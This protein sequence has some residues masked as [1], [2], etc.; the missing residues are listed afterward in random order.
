MAT[1]FQNRLIGTVILVS[2]G[3][4]FLPDLLMGKK[5]DISA[6]PGSLPLRPEQTMVTSTPAESNAN[7]TAVVSAGQ[8]AQVVASQTPVS[9][10]NAVTNSSE[11]V[12][13]SGS[14]TSWQVEDV[15]P[16]VTI[17]ENNT[18]SK[19]VTVS[20]KAKVQPVASKTTTQSVNEKLSAKQTDI[21]TKKQETVK[22]VAAEKTESVNDVSTATVQA[23][24]QVQKDDSGLTIKTPAQVEAE[25][26]A[27]SSAATASTTKPA[28]T[29][30]TP[31]STDISNHN[32]SWIVQVGVFS[33][34]ENAKLLANKLR[35]A[36]YAASTMRSGSLTRV[37]VGPNVSREKLQSQLN[38]INRAAGTAGRVVPYSAIAN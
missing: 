15:A 12:V 8:G 31:A 30:S 7:A 29:V 3:V 11:S 25:R 13:V 18:V 35:S 2:L 38:G 19:P 9:T 36:G 16:T 27:R 32:G 28:A 34:A 17:S 33:N 37:V 10:Q 26:S 6:P 21:A 4:I 14:D 5:N 22:T 20:E 23:A 24:T 1:Q